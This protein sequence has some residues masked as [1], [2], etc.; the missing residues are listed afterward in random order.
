MNSRYY[1]QT[2]KQ[3]VELCERA[4]YYGIRQRGLSGTV[5]EDVLINALKRDLPEFN[6]SRGV[7][8]F[9]DNVGVDIKTKEDLSPQ[10]D[11]ILYKGEPEYSVHNT[12]V[13]KVGQVAGVIE[14]KK[15]LFP[16]NMHRAQKTVENLIKLIESFKYKT[17]HNV[18]VF[19]VTIRFH[20]RL[21]KNV[22]FFTEL[23][24][25]PGSNTY[26]FYGK[27]TRNNR[28]IRFPWKE[29]DW[30][31]FEKCNYAGQYEKL[32]NDIKV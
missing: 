9:S 6:I 3:I 27:Y 26:C 4:N 22:N 14:V 13:V 5:C 29:D 31:D 10:I 23:E 17:D 16:K 19:L 32:V 30:S 20:D 15:W 24:K 18:K 28:K 2:Q 11:I 7:I 1:N 21:Y 12:V 25:Y 8:K